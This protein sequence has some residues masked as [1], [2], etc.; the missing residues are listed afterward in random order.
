V[1][2]LQVAA[3]VA[4]LVDQ[5]DLDLLERNASASFDCPLCRRAGRV[6]AEPAAVV[7]FRDGIVLV[8]RV[9]HAACG[10]SGVVELP[11]LAAELV[12]GRT[13]AQV[14][15]IAAV[16]P[17]A[18]GPRPVLIVETADTVSTRAESGDRVDAVLAR[19]LADGLELVA[20][21]GR[22]P[23]PAPGWRVE[24]P[25]PGL[26]RVCAPDGSV[27]YE[28]Q[29]VLP[30]AWLP[31]VTELRTCLLLVGT[32]LHLAQSLGEVADG[33]RRLNAAGRDGRLVGAV[34]DVAA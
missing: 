33:M 26:L 13:P 10:A 17:H 8:A 18:N 14:T 12:D 34:V 11:G 19:M 24:L 21:V 16:W 5:A 30:G 1:N 4:E 23:G 7:V 25:A 3:E 29:L 15:A 2:V 32:G 27:L 9:V 20:R 22:T 6:P 28:G 31:L